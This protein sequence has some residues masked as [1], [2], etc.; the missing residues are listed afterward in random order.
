MTLFFKGGLF[1]LPRLR[2]DCVPEGSRSWQE[3]AAEL[4]FSLTAFMDFWVQQEEAFEEVFKALK[5]YQL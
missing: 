4:L 5:N 2:G 1:V 3:D